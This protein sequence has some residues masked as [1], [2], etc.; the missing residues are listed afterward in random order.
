VTCPQRWI[1]VSR[2]RIQP[3][4]SA[5][6]RSAKCSCA[7]GDSN[8]DDASRYRQP[9]RDLAVTTQ[10]CV[11]AEFQFILPDP[12][13]ARVVWQPRGSG[14]GVK[15]DF[16]FADRRLVPG[17]TV[18]DSLARATRRQDDAARPGSRWRAPVPP[19][20]SRSPPRVARAVSSR[21]TWRFEPSST[22]GSAG[23][24]DPT[25]IGR[26]TGAMLA[27]RLRLSHRAPRSGGKSGRCSGST[28]GLAAGCELAGD[29]R[30]TQLVLL[31]TQ[32][33]SLS[34]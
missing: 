13:N 3:G 32:G 29:L 12:R 6:T 33:R 21:P 27:R 34:V 14:S 17:V 24:A 23:R 11:R 19:P 10:A 2:I 22:R 5:P 16:K 8:P 25:L 18:D 15:R 7:K 28:S 4:H 26:C 20:G 1:M 9:S 31:S 30:E